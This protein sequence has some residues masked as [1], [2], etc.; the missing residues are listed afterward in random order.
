[1]LYKIKDLVKK[2]FIDIFNWYWALIHIFNHD[3]NTT[4]LTF[5]HWLEFCHNLKLCWDRTCQRRS[6]KQQACESNIYGE[7]LIANK[8]FKSKYIVDIRLFEP[9][10]IRIFRL[11]EVTSYSPWISLPSLGK[12]SFSYLLLKVWWIF[13]SNWKIWAISIFLPILYVYISAGPYVSPCAQ[14]C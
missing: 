12:N 1:M 7:V 6:K 13:L 14:K 11:F 10:L 8:F 3:S 2:I 4:F 5:Y 9:L